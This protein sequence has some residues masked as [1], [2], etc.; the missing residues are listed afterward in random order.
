MKQPINQDGKYFYGGAGRRN[1]TGAEAHADGNIAQETRDGVMV[2]NIAK[3][4]DIGTEMPNNF[5]YERSI[6]HRKS[7]AIIE[8]CLIP[9]MCWIIWRLRHSLN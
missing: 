2:F 5:S 4:M 1:G 6:R 9:G 7:T 3:D 8:R